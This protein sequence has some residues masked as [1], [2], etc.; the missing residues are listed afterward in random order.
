LFADNQGYKHGS[1][2][3][4][5]VMKIAK[6]T[7]CKLPFLLPVMMALTSCSSMSNMQTM[8]AAVGQGVKT[9]KHPAHLTKHHQGYA[10]QSTVH[11]PRH[12]QP[13]V[14]QTMHTQVPVHKQ[15]VVQAVMQAAVV[16]ERPMQIAEAQP[17]MAN[18]MP[19]QASV[20]HTLP[21]PVIGE[22]CLLN[23]H[24]L[25]L[26]AISYKKLDAHAA[27]KNIQRLDAMDGSYHFIQAARWDGVHVDQVYINARTAELMSMIGLGL[28]E[29]GYIESNF[30]ATIMVFAGNGYLDVIP[31]HQFDLSII[32][33]VSSH[34]KVS[35]PVKLNKPAKVS[36]PVKVKMNKPDTAAANDIK[37]NE[38][39]IEAKETEA[40]DGTDFI[41]KGSETITITSNH[42]HPKG[43]VESQN[44][45]ASKEGSKQDV[46]H[47]Q[48]KVGKQAEVVSAT[49][50]KQLC[51]IDNAGQGPLIAPVVNHQA[52][53]GD[54]EKMADNEWGGAASNYST[55]IYTDA[56]AAEQNS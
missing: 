27:S 47:S 54:M 39:E 10:E 43:K 32:R 34:N 24:G 35:K 26:N 9:V 1:H 55:P 37:I 14:R 25:D 8:H 28:L 3:G 49:V 15:N 20:P 23:V 11:Q 42:L 16:P 48:I 12:N 56:P 41:I 18:V 19:H 52:V 38:K 29:D 2:P 17:S 40:F 22:L 4:N 53:N 44:T 31:G 7:L 30:G 33:D 5:C 50:A 45:L 46:S 21:N 36:K 51:H 13:A 6:K